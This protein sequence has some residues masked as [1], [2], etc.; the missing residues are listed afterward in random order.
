VSASANIAAPANAESR[1]LLEVRGL[2]K[3]FGG[4]TA[5]ADLDFNLHK[6]EI[7]G[8]IGPNGAGK[9][10]TFN[11]IA[12]ALAASGGSIVFSGNPILG[13]PPDQIAALGI[14]RTFQHNM[15]FAGL[16][17]AEN[18]LIGMHCR[19]RTRLWQVLLGTKAAR[20]AEESG[21]RRAD[22]LVDFVGLRESRGADVSSLS[23]GQGRLLETARA[24][25]GEPKLML[26][27]E[28]AAGL[29]PAECARLAGIIRGIAA[30]GIAV[31]LIEHDMHF[32]LQLAHRVVVLNFG[33]K[34]ADGP[35]EAIRNDAAVVDAYLGEPGAVQG[36]RAQPLA[37]HAFP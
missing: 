21:R 36:A 14:M 33:R 29:T 37:R 32:L 6:G 30:S 25:A 34:I 15:P 35:P 2:T 12:G 3:R 24:L 27:D 11:L 23:F 31:L 16:S 5:V 26:F 28:P 8:L 13:S 7:L 1:A 20:E 18:V 10:T 4:L 9:T 19:F 22:E 17:V